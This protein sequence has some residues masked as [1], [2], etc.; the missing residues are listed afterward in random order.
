[1]D[2]VT[3]CRDKDRTVKFA[4]SLL[5]LLFSYIKLL[6]LMFCAEI[7]FLQMRKVLFLSLVKKKLSNFPFMN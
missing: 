1:M 5:A 3:V 2:K 6:F 7:T 4:W